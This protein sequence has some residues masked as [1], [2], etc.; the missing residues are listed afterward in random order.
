M[1][2]AMLAETSDKFNAAHTGKL[3]FYIKH[4]PQKPKIKNH[5]TGSKA[6]GG[7]HKHRKN[8]DLQPYL[9]L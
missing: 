1:A 4:Q 8:G 6:E 5:S 9:S 7:A 2:T 3:K